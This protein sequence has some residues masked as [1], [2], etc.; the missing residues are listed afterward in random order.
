MIDLSYTMTYQEFF[1][2][3]HEEAVYYALQRNRKI[4]FTEFIFHVL[5]NAD[6]YELSIYYLADFH[7]RLDIDTDYYIC[8]TK[9]TSDMLKRY[10]KS[11]PQ[12]SCRSNLTRR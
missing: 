7:S 1:Y 5:Y 2:E 11:Q 9:P 4:T 8:D 10:M 6:R 12:S 3:L